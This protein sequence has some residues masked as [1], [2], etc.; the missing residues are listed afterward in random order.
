MSV[1]V[2]KFGGTLLRSGEGRERVARHVLRTQRSGHRVVVVASAIGRAGE[3]YATDTLLRLAREI[4]PEVDARTLDLLLSCGEVISCALLSHLLW[5]LGQPAVALTGAQAGI[6]TTRRF[7]D[8]RILRIRPT[9]VLRALE[10]GRVPVV[11]GFQ[12]VTA[13]GEVT[14]LGRGGSDVTAVALGVAVRAEVVELYKDVDG[15]MTCD[16]AIVPEARRIPRIGYDEVA[17]M[18]Y[19]GARVIHPRAVDVGREHGVRIVVRRLEAEGGTEIVVGPAVDQLIHDGRTVIGLAHLPDVA[20]IRVVLDPGA[21][22]RDA[23]EALRAVAGAGISIDLINLS[24]DLLAF[25]VRLEEAA[26][27]EH[28]IREV[29]LPVERREPCAK[30]SVVGAGIRGVPGVM[31]RVVQALRQEGIPVLQ[32][33]DSHTTISCL[34]PRQQ[35]EAALRALHREFQLAGGVES[36]RE[37]CL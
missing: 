8:A 30:V 17:Q 25:T 2:Q 10:A 13:G 5:S 34:V 28:A 4:H 33:A 11:A 24:Q 29:G 1:I 27:A 36:V 14:T 9:R 7:G 21:G 31:L 3:P 35:M 37:A 16:P 18:A 12:G 22:Q 6:L 19:L 23:L 15:V 26:R 32:T 20:Q